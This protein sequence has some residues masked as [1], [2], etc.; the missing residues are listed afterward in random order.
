M[1]K[2][3]REKRNELRE[4]SKKL[5]ELTWEKNL[6]WEES[7]K[8]REKQE[9][10]YKRFRFYDNIIKANEKVKEKSNDKRRMEV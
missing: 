7:H 2:E 4:T 6:T 8:L 9:E 10:Q 5:R 3:I 1:K